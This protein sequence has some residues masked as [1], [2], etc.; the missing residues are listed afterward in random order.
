[1]NTTVDGSDGKPR[2]SWCDAA[3]DFFHYH[4]TE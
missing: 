3:P 2:C 4:D 1:M